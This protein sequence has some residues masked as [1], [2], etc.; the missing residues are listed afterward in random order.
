MPP[1]VIPL[2]ISPS[3]RIVDLAQQGLQCGPC[4]MVLLLQIILKPCRSSQNLAVSDQFQPLQRDAV[5][6]ISL[7]RPKTDGS[8]QPCCRWKMSSWHR[9]FNGPLSRAMYGS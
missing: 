2:P 4:G 3:H 6:V 7:V 5:Q 1:A 8:V 9:L